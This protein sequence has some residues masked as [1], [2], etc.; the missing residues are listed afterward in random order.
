MRPKEKKVTTI[1]KSRYH[2]FEPTL[3]KEKLE[4]KHGIALSIETV[5]TL[6]V[7]A[8]LW[9]PRGRKTAKAHRSWR[10]RMECGGE[11]VQFDGSYHHWFEDRGGEGCLLAA[12]DDATGAILRLV[13]DAHEGVEPVFRFWNWYVEEHG[14]PKAIYLDKFSTYKVNHKAAKD[15]SELVTQFDRA[16]QTI[17]GKLIVAH[18]PQA[19]GRVERLFGTLQDRM[20]K[21]MRLRGIADEERA[22]KYL[23]EEFVPWFNEHYA[24]IPVKRGDLHRTPTAKERDGLPSTFSVKENRVVTADFTVRYKNEWLQ[25]TKEQT[26]TVRKGDAVIIEERLD[27]SRKVLHEV[28]GRYLEYLVLPERAHKPSVC[29]P[30][31]HNGHVPPQ[32]H[33]WRT[34]ANW[35]FAKSGVPIRDTKTSLQV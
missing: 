2:D 17:G 32:D 12:I 9:K 10:P 29:L 28:R 26:V 25:L 13:F 5:R 30:A 16:L 27:G 34:S 20:V 3:A 31:K 18:S 21:E 33:P 19:K 23:R 8:K 11:L 7:R 15:N 14:V 22:N 6:M 24:V 1:I 4:E 35:L